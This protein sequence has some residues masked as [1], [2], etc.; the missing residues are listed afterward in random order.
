MAGS[1]AAQGRPQL[2]I[3]HAEV[4][5]AAETLLM[6]GENFIW[7]NDNQPIVTLAG[8]PL[9]ILSISVAHILAQLP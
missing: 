3:I 5:L 9:P 7:A 2:R 6:Q 1:A 8:T 4:D